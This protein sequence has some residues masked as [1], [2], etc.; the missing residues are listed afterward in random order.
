MGAVLN[1]GFALDWVRQVLGASWQELYATASLNPSADDPYFLPHL[2][3]ERTPYLDA[4]MRGAWTGLSPR[5][6]RSRLLRAALEGVALTI[7]EAMSWLLHAVVP[8]DHLRLAGGGSIHP[9]WRQLLADVLG[10]TLRAVDVPAA[11]GRGAALLGSRAAGIMDEPALLAVLAQVTELAA[12]EP[13]GGLSAYYG[14]RYQVFTHQ[15][16]TLRTNPAQRGDIHQ[17]TRGRLGAP[18]QSIHRPD[19]LTAFAG[20]APH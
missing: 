3:G 4:D 1:A 20:K 5:H 13:R 10:Y 17:S 2:N 12:V 7:R 9:A 6:D 18:S 14:E 8:I 15:V 19:S 16:H 11:S